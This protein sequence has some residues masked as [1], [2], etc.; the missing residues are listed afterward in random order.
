MSVLSLKNPRQ[1]VISRA[2]R[3]AAAGQLE[4]ALKLYQQA[5]DRNPRNPPIWVQCGHLLKE[6]GRLEAAEAAYRRAIACNPQL[7]DP[8]LQLGHAL[9]LQA[10]LGEAHAAYLR[11]FALDPAAP[12]A[13]RELAAAGWSEEQLAQFNGVARS[14]AATANAGAADRAVATAAGRRKSVIALADR[15]RDAGDWITAARLYRR[16]LDRNPNNPPIWVQYGHALKESG[17]LEEAEGA[18]RT[19]IAYDPRAADTWV[20]LGHVLKQRGRTE[21]ATAAYLRAFA[22]DPRLGDVLRELTTLGWSEA[23]LAELRIAA[24]IAGPTPPKEAAEYPTEETAQENIA[25][26]LV[27]VGSVGQP[28]RR[29]Y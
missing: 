13:A 10:R 26:D 6:L 20:Q 3:A 5:L 2:D 16:A 14:P 25:K 4:E 29:R 28:G 1:S 17:R 19:A 24:G 7:A 9:K 15:A 23:E 22:L 12:D 8:Y 27:G 11:A 18:Y 21:A